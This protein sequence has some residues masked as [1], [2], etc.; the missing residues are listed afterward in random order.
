MLF[1]SAKSPI[2]TEQFTNLVWVC[3]PPAVCIVYSQNLR[4]SDFL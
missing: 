4:Q 1:I 3:I 2:T